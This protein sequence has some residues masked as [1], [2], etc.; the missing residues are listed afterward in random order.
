MFL[1]KTQKISKEQQKL[2]FTLES[3]GQNVTPLLLIQMFA[4][5]NCLAQYKHQESHSA[6][7]SCLITE[8]KQP[9]SGQ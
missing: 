5:W 2:L 9:E 7:Y 8:S 3:M 4:S 6:L 1:E